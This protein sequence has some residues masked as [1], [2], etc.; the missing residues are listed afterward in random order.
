MVAGV[1][2]VRRLLS[3]SSTMNIHEASSLATAICFY[4]NKLFTP[5]AFHTF[6]NKFLCRAKKALSNG[7]MYYY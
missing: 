1:V 5:N 7:K 6:F 3:Q 4:E 2:S